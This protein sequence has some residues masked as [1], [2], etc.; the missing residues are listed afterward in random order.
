MRQANRY[1][2]RNSDW[3]LN[4]GTD[5]KSVINATEASLSVLM[6]IR[7]ELKSLNRVIGCRNFMNIPATLRSIQ[8]SVSKRKIK[9]KS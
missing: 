2:Y 5:G 1:K 4:E 8:K 9:R 6:D 3:T 7:D